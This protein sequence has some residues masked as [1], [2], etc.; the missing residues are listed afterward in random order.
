MSVARMAGCVRAVC[1]RSS[2]ARAFT[3]GS[4]SSTKM[5]RE[6]GRPSSGVITLSASVKTEPTIGSIFR[7]FPSIPT[8]CDPCPV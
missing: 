5:N 6:S 8:Y 2:S 3:V 4:L 7:R 1:L